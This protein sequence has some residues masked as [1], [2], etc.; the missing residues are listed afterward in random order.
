MARKK[1][2]TKREAY[3]RTYQKQ[4]VNRYV[5][6]LNSKHDSELIEA[7]EQLPNRSAWFKEILRKE[8]VQG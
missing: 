5:F 4:Y 3:N 1:N 8:L 2:L 6:K 7:L